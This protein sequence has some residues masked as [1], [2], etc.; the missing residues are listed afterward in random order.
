M[1]HTA[2]RPSS[3]ANP[4]YN[5]QHYIFGKFFFEYERGSDTH[6]STIIGNCFLSEKFVDFFSNRSVLT[7]RELKTT[8]GWPRTL[9]YIISPENVQGVVER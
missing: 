8:I 2:A 6:N 5:K 1:G 9:R 3:C 4:F 7:F